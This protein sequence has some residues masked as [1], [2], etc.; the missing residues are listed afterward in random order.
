MI[1]PTPRNRSEELPGIERLVGDGTTTRIYTPNTIVTAAINGQL[2]R[3][4]DEHYPSIL[5]GK[6]GVRYRSCDVDFNLT[7]DEL[8]RLVGDSLHPQEFK[9]LAAHFGSFFEIH[10]DFY[11]W[12]PGKHEGRSIQPKFDETDLVD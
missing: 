8:V 7:P 2:P 5:T 3:I 6:P 11:D 4:G 10:S 12:D 1:D 9:I